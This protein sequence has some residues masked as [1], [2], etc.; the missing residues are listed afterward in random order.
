M[1]R[2]TDALNQLASMCLWNHG[3][4]LVNT[5]KGER[6]VLCGVTHHSASLTWSQLNQIAADLNHDVLTLLIKEARALEVWSIRVFYDVVQE[7]DNKLTDVSVL[8]IGIEVG[9]GG[10]LPGSD[11]DCWQQVARDIDDWTG[12]LHILCLHEEVSA[13]VDDGI[14]SLDLHLVEDLVQMLES[15]HTDH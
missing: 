10:N 3:L 11:A 4:L 6:D 2:V 13:H 7:G 1:H 14:E 15:S 9:T 12:L 8:H 5:V